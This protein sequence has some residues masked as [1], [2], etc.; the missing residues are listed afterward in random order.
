MI[1]HCCWQIIPTGKWVEKKHVL[2][3]HHSGRAFDAGWHRGPFAMQ[4]YSSSCVKHFWNFNKRW[5]ECTKRKLYLQWKRQSWGTVCIK[6]YGFV[7]DSDDVVCQEHT[8][9]THS[10]KTLP[11]ATDERSKRERCICSHFFAKVSGEALLFVLS[12]PVHLF[13]DC[14][15]PQMA[16]D[17]E[18]NLTIH[19]TTNGTND[20]MHEREKTSW[21][22]DCFLK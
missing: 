18:F 4:M 14:C 2:I 6:I 3:K 5:H 16:D 22:C 1:Y 15:S 9:Y 20:M 7:R 8:P 11:L 17:G 19:A 10:L 21:D 13:L 12:A